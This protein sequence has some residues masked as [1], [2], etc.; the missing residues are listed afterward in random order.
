MSC[1]VYQ[2]DKRTGVRYAYESVSYWD[3][4]KK[5]PRSKRKYVGRVD[6]A[7]GEIIRNVRG[8]DSEVIEKDS[9]AFHPEMDAGFDELDAGID[10]AD[11][12]Q[13]QEKER[14][15]E[16]IERLKSEIA[17]KDEEIF[18]KDSAINALNEEIEELKMKYRKALSI[19]SA[20]STL[21]SSEAI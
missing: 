7:T 13:D 17:A 16:E 6:E 21:S 8:L 18:E 3:K 14:L 9:A 10:L 20:I 5:Q 11:G 2:K 4:E 1:I 12:L 15:N 19:L